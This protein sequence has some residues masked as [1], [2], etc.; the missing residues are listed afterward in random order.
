[1][2]RTLIFAIL[3]LFVFPLALGASDF[4]GFSSGSS[5]SSYTRP[6]A[7]FQTYYGGQI[8]TYWPILGGNNRDSQ[9]EA[10]QDLLIQVAPAGCQPAVVR[11]DLLAEQ[12]VP[13]F[14]QLDALK[15]NPLIDISEIRDIQFRANYPREVISTGFHPAKAA[16]RTKDRLL[17]SPLTSNIGYAVIVL[18]KNANESSLPKFVNVTLSARVD[19]ESGNALG[20]GRAEFLLTPVSDGTW[21]SVESKR[22][23]F[24]QGRYSIR[25]DEVNQN[26]ADISIYYQDRKIAGTRVEKG[27]L[28]NPI[29]LPGSYCQA[30]LQASYDE[31]IGVGKKARIEVGDVSGLDTVDVMEG[32]TFLDGRC[33]VDRIAIDGDTNITG[34]VSVVCS[35]GERVNLQIRKKSTIFVAGDFVSWSKDKMKSIWTV[36]EYKGNGIYLINYRGQDKEV[37]SGELIMGNSSEL[38]STSELD[39]AFRNALDAYELVV[40][41]Y[42]AEKQKDVP[43]TAVY[44][45]TYGAKALEAAISLSQQYGKSFDEARLIQMYLE[46][47]PETG[48][49][50]YYAQR[51]TDIYKYDTTLSANAVYVDGKYRTLRITSISDGSSQA[52]AQLQMGNEVGLK[53]IGWRESVDIIKTVSGESSKV[54]SLR[55]DDMNA[56]EIRVTSFCN[57]IVNG[58]STQTTS[59]NTFSLKLR[60]VQKDICG[61]NIRVENIEVKKAAKIRLIPKVVGTRSEVNVSVGIGIEKRAIQLSPQKTKDKIENLNESIKKWESIS[62]KLGTVVTGLKSACFAT[63]AVL[64]AKTF[65][66]GLSG[67][68]IARQQVMRGPNGWTAKCNEMVNGNPQK[69]PTL[70]ACYIGEANNINADVKA[71]VAAIK[72]VNQN[73]QNAEAGKVTKSG[74]LGEKS[75]DTKSAAK[76]YAKHLIDTY[77]NEKIG[78][79]SLSQLISADCYD[80][81]ECDYTTLRNIEQAILSKRQGVSETTK[82]NLDGDLAK[83]EKQILLNKELREKQVSDENLVKQGYAPATFLSAGTQQKIVSVVSKPDKIVD[84][85]VKDKLQIGGKDPDGTVTFNVNGYS[86]AQRNVEFSGGT[87]I[88]GVKKANNGMY[89]VSS[90]VYMGN[91][92]PVAVA[93]EKISKFTTVY[94]IGPIV[95]QEQVSYSNRYDNPEVRFFE[96][97]PYKGMPALVPFDTTHGWYAATKQTLPTFGGIGGFESSG[98]VASF[99]LCNVGSDKREDFQQSGFGDDLCQLINLN[100]GQSTANF[101]GLSEQQSRDL[102]SRATRALMDAAQQYGNKPI[103]IENQVFTNVK[104]AS[105][106]PAVQC[107]DFMDPKD[108]HLLFNVC[109]P[110]ICPASRCDFGGKYPVAD[111]VQS[112]IIGSTLL[113]LPNAREKIAIPVCLTGI[114]AGIDSYVSLLKSYRDCLR[115]NLASGK[116]IGI[117]DQI[118]SIYLCEFFWRQLAPLAKVILPKLVEAAYG[119]NQGARGGGEYMTVMG[120]WQN[121]QKSLDYFTQTYAVNSLKAYKVRS[122]E[123]A[124]TPV[125]KAFISAGA[126]TNFKSLVE[127]DSPPQFNAWFSSIKFTD[128]TVP[129]TAQYKVYYH[130]FAGKDSGVQYRVYLKSPPETSYYS[131]S[132]YVPVSAG[133]ISKGEYASETKDF[134]APDGYKE[135]CVD[136]NGK[137]ECGFKQVSTSFA[138]NQIRDS[139]VSDELKK[140]NIA[141]EKECVSGSASISGAVGA[142]LTNTNPGSVIEEATM[143]AIYN[144]G[145]IRICSTAN[146]GTSTNPLRFVDVGSCGE[147]RVRCWLDS[148]SVDRAITENNIGVKNDTLQV[149]KSQQISLLEKQGVVLMSDQVV[150][151]LSIFREKVSKLEGDS[152][153]RGVPFVDIKSRSNDLLQKI[154]DSFGSRLD[155]VVSNGH[156]AEV[157][158]L[159]ARIAGAIAQSANL[160]KS[161]PANAGT[162][163]PRNNAGTSGTTS[164]SSSVS[165]N[166]YSLKEMNLKAVNSNLLDVS[167][168]IIYRNNEQ[169]P[170]YILSDRIYIYNDNDFVIIKNLP[171][172]RDVGSINN[173]N[174]A[175]ANDKIDAMVKSGEVGLSMLKPYLSELNGKKLSDLKI[176]SSSSGTATISPSSTLAAPSAPLIQ[177]TTGLAITIPGVNRYDSSKK[178]QVFI[179]G[180]DSGIYLQGDKVYQGNTINAIGVVQSSGGSSPSIFIPDAQS[181]ALHISL[182]GGLLINQVDGQDLKIIKLGNIPSS[183]VEVPSIIPGSEKP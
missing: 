55:L 6:Q 147:T 24:W 163:A 23:S 124:G 103:K 60:D 72:Q 165:T 82:K 139:F 25:L 89:T 181:N 68:G 168:K 19:Y 143:P 87:Y 32:S 151:Q 35:S 162:I 77:P 43:G 113:C 115:E 22:Q 18:R 144:R 155:K 81:L 90:L 127:A 41:E 106:I 156:K 14:C 173:E 8:N 97:E 98:R 44:N 159:K 167:G 92:N 50:T 52:Y 84:S 149:I 108:C 118:N 56:D 96:S 13:V 120:A 75:V 157:L 107:Q 83:Y 160:Q 88:A 64:T 164:T 102:V 174:V 1:M 71:E 177:S 28:S 142:A 7:D 46:R 5:Y 34:N 131:T 21:D 76:Q 121:M 9:C 66:S 136:V 128:A 93:Q 105:N 109:D 101:P 95:S 80:K 27:K 150:S 116:T 26:Y 37:S 74:L 175:I 180:K 49:T 135:L 179:N 91:G 40:D 130:I 51:L 158:F 154:D 86:D 29:Y 2:K 126:P 67:D 31:F 73:V 59:G 70:N 138:V 111:V 153:N 137:E 36:K 61:Q 123:E 65:L 114:H 48:N 100:T 152:A 63:S 15:L 99:W 133:F 30:G 119:G 170:I 3:C 16:L 78:T 20:I 110:V 12:N 169:L 112:G 69:Y 85:T 47:Y 145:I 148:E 178:L 125:C 134:T 42:P 171:F 161:S 94:S 39:I 57:Q 182:N 141:S 10:R 54:G 38:A 79:K 132:P 4:G 129:A 58:I 11:S 172:S 62:K 166:V 146:P 117:C 45:P 140:K 176:E 104:T 17:G 53:R 33:R 122:I 183:G